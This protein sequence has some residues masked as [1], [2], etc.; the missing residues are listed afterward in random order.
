MKKIITF[1]TMLLITSTVLMACGDSSDNTSGTEETIETNQTEIEE[2]ENGLEEKK[3]DGEIE[4]QLDLGIGDTAVI[5]STIGKYE[6]TLESAEFRSEIDG[7]KS[8]LE[9]FILVKYRLKNVGEDS[10]N[11][12]ETIGNLE[13]TDYLEG[14][15]MTDS[16]SEFNEVET[17]DGELASNE[18]AVGEALYYVYEADEYYIVVIEGLVGSGGVKNQIRFTFQA[19]E[20]EES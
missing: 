20:I 1:S 8:E 10:I 12:K 9:D 17:F 7:Q 18:E 13:L 15:G 4:D 2:E 5:E 16:S 19:N 6:I 14:A 3:S 11:I